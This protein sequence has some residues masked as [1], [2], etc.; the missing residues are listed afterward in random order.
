M[1]VTTADQVNEFNSMFSTLN[2]QRRLAAQYNSSS[3][4]A[5]QVLQSLRNHLN[6]LNKSEDTYNQEYLD[7]KQT[8]APPTYFEKMGIRT[9]QDWVL[10]GFFSAYAV[11]AVVFNMYITRYAGSGRLAAIGIV[12][13]LEV[14]FGLI[15]AMIIVKIA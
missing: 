9:L 11:L 7:R 1:S 2:S 15:L 4:N 10:L 5:P 8:L 6:Q 14:T 3:Q 12:A 13:V